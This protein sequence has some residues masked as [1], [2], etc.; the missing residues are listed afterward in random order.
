LLSSKNHPTG[1]DSYVS[2]VKVRMPSH[3]GF[4]EF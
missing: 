4:T 3:T 1:A 2:L